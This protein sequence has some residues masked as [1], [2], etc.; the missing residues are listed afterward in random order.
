MPKTLVGRKPTQTSSAV[1]VRG[2]KPAVPIHNP[3][4]TFPPQPA[5]FTISP[6]L[7]WADLSGGFEVHRTSG[8]RYE[9]RSQEKSVGSFSSLSR[10]VQHAQDEWV[11]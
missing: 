2:V 8:G 9:L 3:T 5:R 4:R 11:M 7:C 1:S 6:S 10:A